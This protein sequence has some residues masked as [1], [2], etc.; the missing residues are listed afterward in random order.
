MGLPQK[1]PEKERKSASGIAGHAI[2][3]KHISIPVFGVVGAILV[4][5]LV[6]AA[7]LTLG[8]GGDRAAKEPEVITESS[9]REIINVS[10]LSTFTAVY[11][12]IAQVTDEE[13][14]EKVDYYVSYQAKVNAGINFE[15][16]GI[17]LEEESKTIRVT[18]PDV[19]ITESIVDIGSLDFIFYDEGA[20]TS[21]VSEEAFKACE[22]DVAEESQQQTAI[23]DLAKQNAKNILTA[24]VRPII[25]QVD[26][27]YQ[28]VVE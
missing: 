26:E 8:P 16:I 18:V 20:N 23:Y 9:L 24:L 4:V 12:G 19:E 22:A 5:V 15:D 1:E 25:E 11:N 27:E 13:D 14:P 2:T 17:D 28:L 7:V 10:E 21:T 6:V 3:V